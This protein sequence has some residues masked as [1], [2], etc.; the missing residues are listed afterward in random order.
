MLRPLPNH[1]TLW[2]HNDDDDHKPLTVLLTI[3]PRACMCMQQLLH[4][5]YDKDMQATTRT[6]KPFMYQ[7]NVFTEYHHCTI[8][9][10]SLLTGSLVIS[11]FLSTKKSL[12]CDK[13]PHK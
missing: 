1:G 9:K 12:L 6:C 11:R 7:T 8:V 3:H 10:I 13:L 5:S 2:L 4:V